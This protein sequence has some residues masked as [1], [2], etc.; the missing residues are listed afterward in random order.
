MHKN[1]QFGK[2]FDGATAGRN[3]IVGKGIICLL[4]ALADGAPSFFFLRALPL[5]LFSGLY[6]PTT[7]RP[8]SLFFADLAKNSKPSC[9]VAHGAKISLVAPVRSCCTCEV[10]SQSAVY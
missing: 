4:F 9:C 1:T 3:T 8:G 7:S 2:D 10:P 6:P 5:E